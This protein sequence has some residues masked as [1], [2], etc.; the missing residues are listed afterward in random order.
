MKSLKS[1]GM[2]SLLATQLVLCAY[3]DE[4]IINNNVAPAAQPAQNTANNQ[5]NN[6][7]NNYDPRV[8]PAGTYHVD[9]GNG[10]SSDIY[11]TGQK[12]PFIVDSNTN[13]TV[14][15]QP[16]VY[17]P[18]PC[19]NCGDHPPREAAA[20]GAA[21]GAAGVGRVGGVGGVSRVGGVGGMRR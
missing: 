15:A 5:N 3:A 10:T 14:V 1:L 18:T 13:S 6:S 20:A 21:A 8:P 16:Y 12:Q 4:T 11:T 7:N 17:G 19:N 2:T 9:N